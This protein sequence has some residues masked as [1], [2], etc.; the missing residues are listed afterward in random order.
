M[1]IPARIMRREL[2]FEAYCQTLR[3]SEMVFFRRLNSHEGAVHPRGIAVDDSSAFASSPGKRASELPQIGPSATTAKT[4]CVFAW[5]IP[6][7]L[8]LKREA[9]KIRSRFQISFGC[10]LRQPQALA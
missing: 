7:W 3:T 9:N 5:G 2:C 1:A 6:A 10:I 8:V 4:G